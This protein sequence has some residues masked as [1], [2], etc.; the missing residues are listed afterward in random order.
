MK[1]NNITNTTDTIKSVRVYKE[2]NIIKIDYRIHQTA[3]LPKGKTGNRFRNSTSKPYSIIAMKYVEK[4]KFTYALKHYNSLFENLENKEEV[5]FKD[6]AYLALKEAEVDRR[7]NDGTKD[8]LSILEKD[9]LPT[10]SKRNLKDLK[11]RDIKEWMQN[12]AKKGKSQSR[13]NKKY[14]VLKRVL[15]YAV[16]NEYID[17]N[18]ISYVKRSSKLFSKPKD[19]SNDYFSK[20]E[21][22]IILNDT[23]ENGT[24]KDKLDHPFINS[25]MN[26]ALF[27]G[28]RTGEIMALKLSDINF[29]GNTIT[30]R[31]SIRRGIEGET[32]T[33]KIRIVPMVKALVESLKKWINTSNRVWVFPKQRIDE[34]YSDSRTIVDKYYKPLLKRLNL[35]FRVLYNT[36]H[37]FA[38]VAVEN[39][40]PLSTVSRCLGHSTISTTERFYLQFG[41]VN[42]EDVRLQ[43]ESLTA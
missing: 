31:R 2:N 30:F 1:I 35:E 36:R 42:Q 4:H 8:Y 3:K 13:F 11:V 12:M 18:P 43:L 23:C 32:K 14:Y 24:L 26:V 20:E 10:F 16:E 28:A 17:S 39:K 15:D 33:G 21:R 7:K 38:S 40:I 6:I 5:T 37:S 41:N 34:P 27:T 19:K 29:E 25:F 9:V 22:N